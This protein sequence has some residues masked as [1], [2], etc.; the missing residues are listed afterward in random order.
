MIFE[1]L[2]NF[3]ATAL[4]VGWQG[5]LALVPG[6]PDWAVNAWAG[7]AEIW[8]Y[9][10]SMDTWIPVDLAVGVAAGVG[11]FWLTS[12]IIQIVR[13]VISY[14]TFGGGAT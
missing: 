10:E 9:V 6:P 14:A 12:I 11:A 1:L 5:L 2:W 7:W 8:A 13:T 3:F 4:L